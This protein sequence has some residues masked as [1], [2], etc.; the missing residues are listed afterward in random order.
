MENFDLCNRRVWSGG[1]KVGPPSH[2][3]RRR[4]PARA[5]AARFQSGVRGFV[6]PSDRVARF[7]PSLTHHSAWWARQREPRRTDSR[8]ASR[9]AQ[10]AS[11]S[12]GLSIKQQYASKIVFAAPNFYAPTKIRL[13]RWAFRC[14][15]ARSLI[16]TLNFPSFGFSIYL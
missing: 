10:L 4:R 15:D 12:V 1:R 16:D 8:S 13:W 6:Q 14:C 7:T 3:P 11:I 9:H 5:R 2:E